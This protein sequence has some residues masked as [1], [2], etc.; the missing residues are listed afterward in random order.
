MD[1]EVP[2]HEKTDPVLLDLHGGQD[3]DGESKVEKNC[4]PYY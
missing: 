3:N 1:L 2:V 4:L